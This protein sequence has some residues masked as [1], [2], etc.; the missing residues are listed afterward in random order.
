MTPRARSRG[1]DALAG[2]PATADPGDAH[3]SRRHVRSTTITAE[4]RDAGQMINRK[5]VARVMRRFGV[6]GLRQPPPPTRHPQPPAAAAG[7]GRTD[8]GRQRRT[9]N[10][11]PRR[12]SASPGIPRR[13]PRRS[14]RPATR[15]RHL[16]GP[17]RTLSHRPPLRFTTAAAAL[18]A[19]ITSDDTPTC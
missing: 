13:P 17:A 14:R 3:R 19:S 9:G 16:A 5:Q 7:P 15:R 11:R 1:W 12:R 2:R 4:L 10:H 6:Q 18:I 8:A